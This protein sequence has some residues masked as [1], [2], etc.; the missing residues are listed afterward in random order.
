M[1]IDTFYERIHPDDRERTRLA[2][3]DSNANNTPYDIEYRTV[4]TDG[5]M[6]W[7]RALGHTFYDSK[8]NPTRFDGLTLDVTERK[9]IEERE[10]AMTAEALAATAKFR[11]VFEQTP[12]FAGILSLYC[13]V[14][15]ANRLCLE[16]CGYRAE[17]TLG[18]PL[19]DTGW[20]RLSKDVQAKIRQAT[21]QAAQGNPF[22]EVLPYHWADNSEHLV[23]F[24]T[25]PIRDHRGQILFLTPHRRRHHR[26]QTRRGELSHFG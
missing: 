12:V 23:G 17:D 14:I 6:K 4:S 3:A 21:L 10:R 11:A 13:T 9:Q 7:V 8:G 26:P 15:D 2:I 5:R 25:H 24:A 16:A 22:R 19:W 18:R 1:T 20:W